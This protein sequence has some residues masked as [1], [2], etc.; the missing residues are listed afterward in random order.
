VTSHVFRAFWHRGPLSPLEWACAK[1]FLDHGHGYVLYSY[2]EIP[3]APAGCVV[4]DAGSVLPEEKVF[5]YDDALRKGSVAG[6]SN[7]FRYE[8]LR[9]AGGWWVDTDV[10]CLTSEVPDTP[11]V[12]AKEDE[13]LYGNAI[14]RVPQGCPL[15]EAA[16]ARARELFPATTFGTTGPVLLTELIRELG[17]EEAAWPTADL[18]PVPWTRALE[19]FDPGKERQ[20]AAEV[21]GSRFIHLWTSVLKMSNVLT[22]VRPPAGS[23]LAGVYDR[24]DVPFASGLEYSWSDIA[25]V[26]VLQEEHQALRRE[27]EGALR[28]LDAARDELARLEAEN[29]E[30]RDRA[31]PVRRL[32]RSIAAKRRRLRRS[33]CL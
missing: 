3:N 8:L 21:S 19:I 28:K 29:Q 31:G 2:S 27:Y 9:D 6:F 32:A 14:L 5:F 13:T 16:L 12:F 23:F 22:A 15:M 10:L 33:E 30:L 18:Y 17:L 26:V 20:I 24:Y 7:L 25:S 4:E 11:Y 1:S